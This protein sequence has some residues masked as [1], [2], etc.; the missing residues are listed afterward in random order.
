MA[1]WTGSTWLNF[2]VPIESFGD[3]FFAR[4]QWSYRGESYNTLEPT[5]ADGNFPNP[6]LKND[7]YD[8]GDL[9]F[10]VRGERWE[11]SFFVE[12]L[13]DE[14]GTYTT[15]SG[16]FEWSAASSIDG[17]AHT[18]KDYLIRPREYG[19]RFRMSFGD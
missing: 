2:E 8:Q 4:L 7:S 5:E 11:L 1:D 9:Y 16:L 12:N 10:G 15:E 13:T 17:R 19:M 18:Q 14:R 3:A 6:Q